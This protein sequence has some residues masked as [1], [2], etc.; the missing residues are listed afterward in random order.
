M[1]RSNSVDKTSP[2]Y[3]GLVK[4]LVQPLLD[5]PDTLSVDCEQYNH[6]QRVWI[7]LAFKQADKGKV[8]GRGGR[9]LEAIKTILETAASN[10]GQS[11][12]LDIY[13]S[14]NDHSHSRDGHSRENGKSGGKEVP[15]KP[16]RSS[17]KPSLPSRPN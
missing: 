4:F 11:L 8:Y 9:N 13:G 16:A 14:Q 7:R 6:N 17:P 15:K 12:Y 2:D 10:V 3:V 5:L 1:P